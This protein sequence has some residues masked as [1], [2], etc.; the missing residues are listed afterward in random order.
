M[1]GPTPC[2]DGYGNPIG[3]IYSPSVYQ[4]INLSG[5]HPMVNGTNFTKGIVRLV[6]TNTCNIKFGTSVTEAKI[7]EGM[8]L[9][10]NVPELFH[11]GDNTRISAIPPSGETGIL[12]ITEMS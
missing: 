8:L 4:R 1:N 7:N 5:E 10:E 12:Y 2:I 11:V 9:V 6:T 3:G